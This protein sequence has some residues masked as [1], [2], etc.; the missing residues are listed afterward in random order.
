MI[1]NVYFHKMCGN[2]Y[3]NFIG[4]PYPLARIIPI[5]VRD[6]IEDWLYEN[7]LGIKI[8][9]ECGNFADDCG[10]S[11]SD[12]DVS[13]VVDSWHE[14]FVHV[15]YYLDIDFKSAEVLWKNLAWGNWEH[16]HKTEE[17]EQYSE[18]EWFKKF[19]SDVF[20]CSD[21]W[22]LDR[23]ERCHWQFRQWIKKTGYELTR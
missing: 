18:K 5:D 20:Y 19:V 9:D 6:G 1:K 2:L 12:V 4:L 22:S 15:C 3:H 21:R 14:I 16:L 11:Y 23:L 10:G 8:C 17:E 7:S 13:K